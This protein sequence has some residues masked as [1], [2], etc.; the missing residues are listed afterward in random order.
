MRA[1]IVH[2]TISILATWKENPDVTG[3]STLA[4]IPA[5]F[6]EARFPTQVKMQRQALVYIPEIKAKARIPRRIHS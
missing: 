3:I 1:Q 2:P 5:G 4:F 6:S